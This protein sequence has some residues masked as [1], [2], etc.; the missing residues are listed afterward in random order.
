MYC[1]FLDI[2]DFFFYRHYK[3]KCL[4]HCGTIMIFYPVGK[5]Y[6]PS[7]Y[8]YT[9][10]ANPCKGFHSGYIY[11]RFITYIY[12][13]TGPSGFTERYLHFH[14]DFKLRKHC[15]RN[16]VL[17]YFIQLFMGYINNYSGKLHF[18]HPF[19]SC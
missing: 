6:H 19:L 7:V 15:F 14:P 2:S 16:Y 1:L 18:I 5:F 17:K 8:C 12:D 13:I 4:I 11:L 9:V 10:S 3:F